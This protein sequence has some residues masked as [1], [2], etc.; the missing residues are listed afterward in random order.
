MSGEAPRPGRGHLAAHRLSPARIERATASIDPVFL[1]SPQFEAESLGGRLGCRLVVKVETVNPIRSFKG[2]GACRFVA[3]VDP[4]ERLVCA[5]AGNFGQAMAYACRLRGMPLVVY[6]AVDASPLKVERMRAL[7]ADVRLEGDDFDAAKDAAR[8]Y[9]ATTGARMVEDGLE[10]AISEGAG[11]MAVELLR[12]PWHLDATVVPLGNGAMLGGVARWVTERSPSTEIV[13]VQ[14][15]GAPAMARSWREGTIVEHPAE[16]IA[17][18]IA[19]RVPIPAAVDDM[20]AL[21]DDVVLVDD[22]I[23]IAAMRLCHAELGLVL[24]PAG[25]V[26]VAAILATPQ[27]WAGRT[28]AT[29]LCGGNLV[30]GQMARW[31]G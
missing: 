9:A 7:G 29:I 16:T 6:A 24:E 12:G 1:D 22:E 4:A 15:T 21:V 17:D 25:A 26:G 19:V 14:A 23:T 13:A 8:A 28:V 11:T 31:L 30:P 10:P 3:G 18:G 20:R 2:R 5:S 27:R